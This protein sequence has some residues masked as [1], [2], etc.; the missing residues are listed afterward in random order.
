MFLIDLRGLASLKD[1]RFVIYIY[2]D[3]APF[4]P[5]WSLLTPFDPFFAILSTSG[6][7]RDMNYMKH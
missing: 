5:F 4:G 3:F 2:I 7:L 6:Q 1:Q